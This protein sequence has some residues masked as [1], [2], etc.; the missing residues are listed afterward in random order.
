VSVSPDQRRMPPH[1]KQPTGRFFRMHVP[2]LFARFTAEKTVPSVPIG[3]QPLGLIDYVAALCQVTPVLFFRLE[4]AIAVTIFSSKMD[5]NIRCVWKTK[6]TLISQFIR[7]LY[8]DIRRSSIH[9]FRCLSNKGGDQTGDR[10]FTCLMHRPTEPSYHSIEKLTP[11]NDY[12]RHGYR[13]TTC[14]KCSVRITESG[15]GLT[16]SPFYAQAAETGMLLLPVLSPV[17]IH[18]PIIRPNK[19]GVSKHTGK[20]SNTEA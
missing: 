12:V 6:D 15:D 9:H 14:R 13:K 2:T 20:I 4:S 17:P 3:I 7:E 11:S 18:V 10:C 8:L 16:R 5:F 19:T 1:P